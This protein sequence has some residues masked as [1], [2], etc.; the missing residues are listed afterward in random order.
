MK[1]NYFIVMLLISFLCGGILY[2][3]PMKLRDY[4]NPG[5][6]SDYKE[7]AKE[8]AIYLDE[9]KF[10][11]HNFDISANNQFI[12]KGKIYRQFYK[13]GIYESLYSQSNKGIFKVSYWSDPTALITANIIKKEYCVEKNINNTLFPMVI[14]GYAKILKSGVVEKKFQNIKFILKKGKTYKDK[15]LNI[16][17]FQVTS[18]PKV[19]EGTIETLNGNLVLRGNLTIDND[20]SKRSGFKLIFSHSDLPNMSKINLKFDYEYIDT[21]KPAGFLELG[22][23]EILK[24]YEK[25]DCD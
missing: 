22:I 15:N 11:V 2:S 25:V 8:N 6:V 14:R 17:V 3:Q 4:I 18:E 1:R 20:L 16:V 5:K 13:N 9:M 19:I 24:K 7:K 10:I 23:E 21:K 12:D